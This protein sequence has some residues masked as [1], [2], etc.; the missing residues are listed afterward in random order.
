MRISRIHVAT[1]LAAESEVLLPADA[2]RHLLRVLRLRPGAVVTL[3]DG[4]GG[5]YGATL[6]GAAGPAARVHIGAHRELERES[7]LDCTLLQAVSRGERMDL[8]IQK[9]VELGVT[10]IVPVMTEFGV[11]KLDAAQAAKRRAH[12]QGIAISAC[13]QCGRN[14]VPEIAT[15]AGFD[16][17][18]AALDPGGTRL[19]LALDAATT[20]AAAAAGAQRA[21]LLIGP[22]GGLSDAELALA[23]RRQFVACRLGP[24]VLRTETAPLAALALLQAIAGDLAR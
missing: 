14:R 11:V 4:R 23:A 24:R 16:A 15:P 10:R 2:S 20:L 7:P 18:Y 6:L 12:W 8:I 9:A 17:V 21:V 22:E 5:E 1:P 19:L 3:F 13:E